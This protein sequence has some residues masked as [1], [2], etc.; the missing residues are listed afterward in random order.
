[1]LFED[2]IKDKISEGGMGGCEVRNSTES[3]NW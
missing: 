2:F 3:V 1:M